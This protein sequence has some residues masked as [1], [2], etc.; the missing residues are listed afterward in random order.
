M[1][2]KYRIVCVLAISV[3]ICNGLFVS[4]AQ[5]NSADKFAFE[6]NKRLGR[7]V[8]IIGYDKIWTMV[9]KTPPPADFGRI[10]GLRKGRYGLSG[11]LD[12]LHRPTSCSPQ[13]ELELLAVRF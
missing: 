12:H 11:T 5:E 13:L 7:G 1:S 10:W 8:N 9:K 2:E 4:V 6:Q 3:L